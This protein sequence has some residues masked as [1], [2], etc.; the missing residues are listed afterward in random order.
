MHTLSV[1][2]SAGADQEKDADIADGSDFKPGPHS[3]TQP[4]PRI[5]AAVSLVLQPDEILQL[6]DTV[7]TMYFPGGAAAWQQ[8]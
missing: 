1:S 8:L 3:E 7:A 2:L 5:P 4:S 6:A